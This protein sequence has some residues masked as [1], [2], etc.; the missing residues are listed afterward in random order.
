MTNSFLMSTDDRGVATVTLNRPDKHNAF[1]DQLI[2]EL[3][4]QLKLIDEDSSI[5]LMVLTGSGES[6]SS[7]A[8]L[9]WMQS[10][11]NY[12]VT[13]NHQDAMQLA[14]LM[15]TLH[16]LSQPTIARVNGSA[17]GGAIGL[18]ACCDMAIASEQAMFAFSEIKLGIAPAVIS[19]YVIAA[20]GVH[21][22]KRLFLTGEFFSATEAHRIGLISHCVSPNELDIQV[23][24]Y[25]KLLLKGGQQAQ[26]SI[27]EL[28]HALY[29]IDEDVTQASAALIAKLRTSEE[30]QEGLTAFLEKRP[31]V[32]KK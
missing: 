15:Q 11:V 12:D 21:Q 18:I 13:T 30:G 23:E 7:G 9:A 19:P 1:D 3:T 24:N 14:L 4:H 28:L 10:M 16:Q 31:P 20:I 8:D 32:W 5:R 2:Q 6:F 29:P 17:F 25:L 26:R 22:A 27:K